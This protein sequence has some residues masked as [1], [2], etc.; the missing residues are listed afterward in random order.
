ML[1]SYIWLKYWALLASIACPLSTRTFINATL[2]TKNIFQT[3][4]HN[5]LVKLNCPNKM[6]LENGSKIAVRRYPVT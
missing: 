4:T 6:N 5:N 3:Q 1:C 2:T